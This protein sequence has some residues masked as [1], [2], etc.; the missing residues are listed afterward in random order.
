[1]R[2]LYQIGSLIF[3]TAIVQQGFLLCFVIQHFESLLYMQGTQLTIQS[4]A[5]IVV[6]TVR[7]ITI[8]LNLCHMGSLTQGMHLT[9]GDIG[10]IATLHSLPTEYIHDSV[11]AQEATNLLSRGVAIETQQ[12]T[13]FRFRFVHIPHLGL[14]RQPLTCS[15]LIIGMNLHREVVVHMNKLT[16][17]RKRIAILVIHPTTQQFV[18]V[19]LHHFRQGVTAEKTVTHNGCIVAVCRQHPTL[20]T[21]HLGEYDGLKEQRIQHE[22]LLGLN[23]TD[24]LLP[25]PC[26]EQHIFYRGIGAPA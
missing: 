6:Q 1:M 4:H 5:V 16:E 25:V 21:P 10:C 13:G 2:V 8:L 14:A 12:D 7:H 24:S 20:A 18:H 22:P 17:Q 3:A 23:I 19:Y 11:L 9:G 26:R 15:C